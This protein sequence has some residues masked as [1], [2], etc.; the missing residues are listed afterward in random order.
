MSNGLT[1]E[2]QKREVR[3]RRHFSFRLNV[4]FSLHLRSF[5]Y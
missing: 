5:P 3:N 1:E 4:F 2:A